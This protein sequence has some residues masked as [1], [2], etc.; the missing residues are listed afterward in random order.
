MAQTL[1]Q[2]WQNTFGSTSPDNNRDAISAKDVAMGGSPGVQNPLST[3]AK[4][5]NLW[6]SD[7]T[8]P[9]GRASS[10]IGHLYNAYF[11][12]EWGEI[13]PWMT[14]TD[15]A[16]MRGRE[17]NQTVQDT[18]QWAADSDGP[19]GDYRAMVAMQ[20]NFVRWSGPD[21]FKTFHTGQYDGVNYMSMPVNRGGGKFAA[22]FK[23]ADDYTQMSEADNSYKR[24][25][26]RL[27]AADPNGP[28]AKFTSYAGAD[29]APSG[30]DGA[31]EDQETTRIGDEV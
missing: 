20:G 19:A 25:N 24:S 30:N 4:A 22:F 17:G 12:P 11:S 10:R 23:A 9:F 29:Q 16:L 2:R 18:S 13:G 14:D 6:T 27:G 21:V 3:S 5:A 31:V 8:L 28:W 26:Y 15:A 1:L 7:N